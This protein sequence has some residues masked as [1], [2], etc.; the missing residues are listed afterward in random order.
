[1]NKKNVIIGVLIISMVCLIVSLCAPIS[2]TASENRQLF[3]ASFKISNLSI[4]E[5]AVV[6][7]VLSKHYDV[8]VSLTPV[9]P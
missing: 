1:M 2:S 8:E 7:D 6:T 4:Q 5:V 3:N 9:K